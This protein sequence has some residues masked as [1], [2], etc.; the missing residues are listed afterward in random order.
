MTMSNNEIKAV[1]Y[2]EYGDENVLQ[3]DHVDRPTPA[4]EEVLVEIHAASINPIDTYVRAGAVGAG[5]LP[6]TI[7][8]DVAGVVAETGVDVEDFTP[9]DRVYSTCRGVVG[10]GTVAEATTIPASALATLPSEVPFAEGAAAAMTFATAWRALVARGA[11]SL[12]DR[13]LISGASGGVGHAGVQVAHAAGATVIGLARPAFESF[14]IGLGADALVDYRTADLA[15]EITEAADGPIDVVLESHA[16]TNLDGGVNALA[17]GGRIVII[18]EEEPIV[19]DS[20]LSMQAKQADTD[21][22]FMSLA[23]S[24]EDQRPILE[25]IAPH[26]ADDRFEP[27]IDS[28]FTL[29]ETANAYRRL[30][31]TG[32]KGSI[33]IDI[34]RM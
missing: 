32:V 34:Q 20:A 13:C 29:A 26:L 21:L 33:V 10:D 24:V 3:V 12:G 19:L 5:T 11:V 22:R 25:A 18:G 17:R 6:R 28:R 31:E 30:A 9:G 27:H 2:H 23:A 4:A 8:S 15:S 14:I 1:R 7:G 16:G